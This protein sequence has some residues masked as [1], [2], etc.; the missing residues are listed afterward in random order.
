M[1]PGFRSDCGKFH[2]ISRETSFIFN[3]VFYVDCV[4]V[5]KQ[6]KQKSNE[7]KLTFISGILYR[8]KHEKTLK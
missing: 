6:K 8:V 2:I 7:L 3:Y 1:E 5:N 4:G